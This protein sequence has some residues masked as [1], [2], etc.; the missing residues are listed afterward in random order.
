M[1]SCGV[2]ILVVADAQLWAAAGTVDQGEV[3]HEGSMADVVANPDV[4]KNCLGV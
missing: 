1:A 3:V 4:R 2:G